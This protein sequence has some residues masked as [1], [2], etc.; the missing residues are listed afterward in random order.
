MAQCSRRRLLL[1]AA[2]GLGT[3]LAWPWANAG[4]EA[5]AGSK[6]GPGAATGAGSGAEVADGVA[7]GVANGVVN[8]VADEATDGA[9]RRVLA[10]GPGAL[11]MLVY[12]DAVE[13]LVGL[14][15]M[16]RRPL[17]ASTYRFVLPADIASLPVAGPGGPGRLPDPERLLT[18]RPDLLV[19]VGLDDQQLA[20]LRRR[21]GVEA[22]ALSYGALGALEV[23]DFSASLTRLGSALGLSARAAALLGF[24]EDSIAD[25]NRRVQRVLDADHEADGDGGP[26]AAYLG[27]I[28][29]SGAQ[30]IG[31]TQAGHRPLRWAGARNLADEVG[32]N[33]HLFLD[34]EQLLAW[35][36]PV[37]FIDAGGLP[38]ILAGLPRDAE[39][40]QRL[41]AVRDGRVYLTLPFNAY[42][43]NVENALVN[44]WFIA[45]VLYPRA[46]ADV[47]LAEQAA[48]IFT[49]FLGRDLLAEV[50]AAGYGPGRVDLLAGTWAPWP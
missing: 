6:V 38:G 24:F 39:F 3:L 13:R 48:A 49:A 11:R 37:L 12:L 40:Y 42:N 45:R 10:I 46:L 31:S 5:G 35:D 36:P 4:A 1:A 19:T 18:L 33:G 8:G 43:T 22:L 30:G 47:D 32:P 2:G 41:R 29:L 23:A 20:V 21:T 7:N 44:A 14:E 50:R 15:D 27:G 34:R 25:L 28:S 16:E 9:P 26:Q 17:R